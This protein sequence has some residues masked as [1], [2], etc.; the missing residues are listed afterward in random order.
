MSKYYIFYD[1]LKCDKNIGIPINDLCA[2]KKYPKYNWIYNRLELARYQGLDCAPMPIEPKNYPIIIKP[3]INLYGMGLNC[4]K[5]NDEDEFY[6]C[7]FTNGFW[8]EF[9]TGEHIS[10]DIVLFEGK[11]K[12]VVAFQGKIDHQYLGKF[13]YW[14]TVEKDLPDIITKLIK[15][16]LNDFNGCVNFETIDNKIIEGHLRTGDIFL[17]ED[18]NIMKGISEAYKGNDFDWSIVEYKPIYFFPVWAYDSQ[19]EELYDILYEL[20]KPIL[21]HDDNIIDFEI[22]DPKMAN[23]ENSRRL[24]WFSSKEKEYGI[25]IREQIYELLEEK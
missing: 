3:I 21:R 7:W 12:Y 17:M 19:N 22:D 10:W 18:I 5:V 23:P 20:V 13:D 8:M 24:L 14:E 2:W 25:D 9:L 16:K 1:I 15:E 11:I 6:D 4:K